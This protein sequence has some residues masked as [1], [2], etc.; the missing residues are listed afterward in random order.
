MPANAHI[1]AYLHQ[2]VDLGPLADYRVTN[3]AAV[4][5]R[6]CAYLDVVLNNHAADL[7]DLEVS[8]TAHHVTGAVLT[9]L[10]TGM[11]DDPIADQSIAQAGSGSDRA[12]A[13]YP[14]IGADYGVCADHGAAANFGVWSDYGTRVDADSV[15]GAGTGVDAGMSKIACIGQRRWSQCVRKQSARRDDKGAIRFAHGQ[16]RYP[17]RK[18]LGQR[19]G[20]EARART[21]RGCS[22]GKISAVEEREI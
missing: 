8:L 19:G 22:L 13:S 14:H 10:A 3:C 17:W 9:D 7:R 12:I 16:D 15:F 6:A 2:V 20:R 21:G 18:L 1:V 11:D 4:N 5:R